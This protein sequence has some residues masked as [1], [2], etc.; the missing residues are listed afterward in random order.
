M[1]RLGDPWCEMAISHSHVTSHVTILTRLKDR[2]GRAASCA[3]SR[4]KSIRVNLPEPFMPIAV[5]TDERE[6]QDA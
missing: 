3:P 4:S 5:L 1:A 6:L 2:S